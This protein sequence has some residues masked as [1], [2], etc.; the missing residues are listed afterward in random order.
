MRLW[1]L[2]ARNHACGNGHEVRHNLGGRNLLECPQAPATANYSYRRMNS[3]DG[4]EPVRRVE[5]ASEQERM[6]KRPPEGLT[7]EF[8]SR[9]GFIK[10]QTHRQAAPSWRAFTIRRFD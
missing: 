3:R 6:D 8:R 4:P 1:N 9:A 10:N 5:R 7:L 2:S